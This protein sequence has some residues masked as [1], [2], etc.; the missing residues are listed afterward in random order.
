M[1]CI[2]RGTWLGLALSLLLWRWLLPGRGSCLALEKSTSPG[3]PCPVS[4]EYHASRLLAGAPRPP[5][6]T[7]SGPRFIRFIP[8]AAHTI[9]YVLLPRPIDRTTRPY[10]LSLHCRHSQIRSMQRQGLGISLRARPAKGRA[11]GTDRPAGRYVPGRHAGPVKA[12]ARTPPP[13]HNDAKY[14]ARS[15]AGLHQPSRP[16]H[17]ALQRPGSLQLS[18]DKTQADKSSIRYLTLV[19][20]PSGSS[21]S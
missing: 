14:I 8:L 13:P 18:F 9:A 6:P 3:S 4:L 2:G 15:L 5:C 11:M 19:V 7:G 21:L 16:A 10:P 20:L 1:I 12:H 17:A